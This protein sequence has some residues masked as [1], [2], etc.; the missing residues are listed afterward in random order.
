MAELDDKVIVTKQKITDIADQIRAELSES[1]EYKLDVMPTKIHEVAQGGG[2]S[3]VI[4]PLSVTQNGTY[5][6]TG[7]VDGYSP[8]TV[9]VEPDLED[10]TITQNGS[11]KSSQHDGYDDVIVNVAPV[12][13]TTKVVSEFD[14]SQQEYDLIRSINPESLEPRNKALLYPNLY[15]ASYNS[16][17]GYVAWS[18]YYGS[19]QPNFFIN[20][21]KNYV[22]EINFGVVGNDYQSASDREIFSI[23][24]QLK[25]YWNTQGYFTRENSSGYESWTDL[26][27]RD[28][29][30][31]RKLIVNIEW[32]LSGTNEPTCYVSLVFDNGDNTTTT[33]FFGNWDEVG[34]PTLV[35]GRRTSDNG[36]YPVQVKGIKI[37]ES[38]WELLQNRE[39]SKNSNDE[40]EETNEKSV[41][42][43]TIEEKTDEVKEQKKVLKNQVN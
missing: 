41:E 13:P 20:P 40:S 5:T 34:A 32:A 30:T 18:N 38:K 14:F 24:D 19:V 8:V 23:G 22:I 37:T 26:D 36:L 28:Y 31:N 39:L 4:N 16:E 33:K 25:L 7:N 11:Y 17:N 9:A 15:N 10:I 21:F 3:A 2:G 1:D 29:L 27:S 43:E 42:K 6:A 35:I 12:E